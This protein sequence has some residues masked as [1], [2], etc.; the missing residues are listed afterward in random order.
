MVDVFTTILFVHDHRIPK[1]TISAANGYGFKM[2]D[3]G[4]AEE[5]FFEVEDVYH[6]PDTKLDAFGVDDPIETG[7]QIP[8]AHGWIQEA[9]VR[10]LLSNVADLMDG[11]TPS[12]GRVYVTHTAS[13]PGGEA[14]EMPSTLLGR[15][16]TGRGT[17]RELRQ[18]AEGLIEGQGAWTAVE[19]VEDV[20]GGT[21][22]FMS[23][24]GGSLSALADFDRQ[25][26]GPRNKSV[27]DLSFL[28]DHR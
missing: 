15:Y 17:P 8:A 23:G 9:E 13:G 12:L 28:A 16:E 21:H 18:T 11:M 20:P 22:L 14:G 10:L 2:A 3:V 19:R 26:V 27:T 25:L 24:P 5:Q 1:A 4:A 7:V 6:H